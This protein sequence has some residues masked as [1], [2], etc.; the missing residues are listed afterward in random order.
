VQEIQPS[1]LDGI[2]VQLPRQRIDCT[3]DGVRRLRPT[4]TAVGV[5]RR[6]RR[7]DARALEVVPHDVVGA[8]V[9]PGSQERDP[10]GHELEIRAHRNGQ[11]GANRSDL[12]F[13]CRRQLDLLDQVAAVD[14]RLIAL[15]SRL[16]PLDRTAELAREHERERFL[17]VDVELR[18]EA[19]ADV[20]CDHAQLRLRNSRDHR[21]GHAR[22]VGNLRRRPH[23]QLARCRER[24]HDHSAR[25][26]RIRNQALLSVALLDGDIGVRELLLDLTG[27]QRPRVAAVRAEV[28]VNDGSA[29]FECA[30]GVDD[31]RKRLIVHLHELG[32]VARLPPR[33]RDHDRDAVAHVP[34]LVDRER[35]V[36]RLV[37]VLGRKPGTRQRR[38]PLVGEIL[39]RE[40]CDH[41]AVCER[42]RHVDAGDARV[43]IWR[44]HDGHPDHPGQAHV[45]DELRLTRE[46]SD[47]FFPLDRRAHD[48]AERDLLFDGCH[49]YTPAPAACCTART[50]LW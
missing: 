38:E 49:R 26:N 23:R 18:T 7:E 27:G 35:P 6:R 24:L 15:G 32:C 33:L 28:I 3:F 11:P 37:R 44:A 20:R 19:A 46:E 45:V 4:G 2:L 12:A 13:G 17:G 10:G 34:R 47:V 48:T 21:E 9:Q 22:D 40:S 14:R 5:R 42:R 8:G 43:C 16:D 50:M 30:L 1:D 36:I 25:L 41:A 39:A 29:V 31:G